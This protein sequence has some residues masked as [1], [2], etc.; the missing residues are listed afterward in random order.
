[1]QALFCSSSWESCMLGAQKQREP[2]VQTVFTAL[3]ARKLSLG[4][5]A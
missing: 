1:M 4:S 2:F 3:S 5:A